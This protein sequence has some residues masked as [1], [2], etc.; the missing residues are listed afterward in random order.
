MQAIVIN[1]K[2]DNDLVDV[3]ADEERSSRR[4][5]QDVEKEDGLGKY[6]DEDANNY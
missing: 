3:K 6:I 5:R 1:K 4:G 2:I